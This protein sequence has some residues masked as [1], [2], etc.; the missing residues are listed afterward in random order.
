[1]ASPCPSGVRARSLTQKTRLP[2]RFAEKGANF[3]PGPEIFRLSDVERCSRAAD[4]PP[5]GTLVRTAHGERE[6]SS[7]H[8]H[9]GA[10]LFRSRGARHPT[11]QPLLDPED[12]VISSRPM[13]DHIS[14]RVQDFSR[15]VDFYK[16]ALA[17][18]GYKVLMEFPNVAGMGAE[19][20]ADLWIMQSEQQPSPTHIAING[21]RLQIQA[22]HEAA[23]TSGGTD[24]GPPGLRLDYHPNYFAAF[25]LDPEGNNIE[26]VCHAPEGVM[27][28][29]KKLAAKKSVK[30]SA[31]AAGKSASKPAK[32]V[33]A[34]KPAKK[35]A[36]AAKAKPAKKKKR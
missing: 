11:S 27:A 28:A 18:L 1:M 7:R 19:G 32:K 2:G 8:L 23:L 22:F 16:T 21:E 15:A 29:P 30:A 5:N 35:A 26:V 6:W 12:V 10:V 36:P 14:L 34:K 9:D 33:A 17:P 24:N 13:I 4:P 3:L 20:K 25:V 31:K